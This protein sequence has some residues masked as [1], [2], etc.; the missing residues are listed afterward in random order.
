MRA[1]DKGNE[2]VRFGS[3][4]KE[5]RDR[6]VTV[7]LTGRQEAVLNAVAKRLRTDKAE[8]VRQALDFWA[9]HGP[10]AAL[11]RQVTRELKG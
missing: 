2:P 9:E 3:G 10:E 5:R 1:S 4:P 7:R 6:L 11:V 8:V